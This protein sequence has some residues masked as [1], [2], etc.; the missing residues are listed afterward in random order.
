MVNNVNGDL[1]EYSYNI[2][3]VWKNNFCQLLGE[4]CVS[5]VKQKEIHTAES[6]APSFALEV[7]MAIKKLRGLNCHVLVKF[8][9]NLLKQVKH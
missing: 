3:N 4:H 1:L 5:D 7:E 9:E 6:L 8:R 2:L